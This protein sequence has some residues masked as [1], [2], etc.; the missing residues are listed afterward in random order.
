MSART[1]KESNENI[2]TPKPDK[3]YNTSSINIIMDCNEQYLI[4]ENISSQFSMDQ[5][6]WH[7]EYLR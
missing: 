1:G 3:F 5:S 6:Y 7:L 4:Y 2:L